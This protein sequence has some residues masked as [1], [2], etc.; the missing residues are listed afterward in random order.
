MANFYNV[1]YYKDTNLVICLYRYLPIV[2]SDIPP[3]SDV[4]FAQLLEISFYNTK[5]NCKN[6]SLVGR[7]GINTDLTNLILLPDM[8]NWNE[9]YKMC[10]ESNESDFDE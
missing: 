8:K 9:V 3:L 10:V 7:G 6:M 5:F 4:Q 2:V 1:D